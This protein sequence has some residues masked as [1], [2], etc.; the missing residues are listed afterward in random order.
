MTGMQGCE[1]VSCLLVI[2]TNLQGESLREM[3]LT[4]PCARCGQLTQHV[5]TW[6]MAL[7]PPVRANIEEPFASVT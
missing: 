4:V 5:G 1:T 6:E 7:M 3:N 2:D